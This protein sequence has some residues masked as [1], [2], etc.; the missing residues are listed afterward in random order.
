MVTTVNVNGRRHGSQRLLLDGG[1]RENM[2]LKSIVAVSTRM[3]PM[4]GISPSRLLLKITYVAS[5]SGYGWT[6]NY[7]KISIEGD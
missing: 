2:V 3:A 5:M 4:N 7:Q 1:R 6:I